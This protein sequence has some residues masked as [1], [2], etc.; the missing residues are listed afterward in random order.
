V[1]EDAHA[2]RLVGRCRS[3]V[4][5]GITPLAHGTDIA[6]SIRFPAYACGI[7]GIRPSFGRVPS[8]NPTQTAERSLS[9]S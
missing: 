1:V 8:Y 5:A 6:G 7:A 3:S 4:A 9:R 2:G